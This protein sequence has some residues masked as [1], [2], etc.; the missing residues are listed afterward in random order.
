MVNCTLKKANGPRET[1]I[2]ADG[3]RAKVNLGKNKLGRTD[4]FSWESQKGLYDCG[5]DA[6]PQYQDESQR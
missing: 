1:L 4:Q 2:R 5:A 6:I 3:V